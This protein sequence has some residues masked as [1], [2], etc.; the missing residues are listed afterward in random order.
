M[1][2]CLVLVRKQS[3]LQVKCFVEGGKKNREEEEK[4][5]RVMIL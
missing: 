1:Y 5:Y 4:T 3:N 2:Q